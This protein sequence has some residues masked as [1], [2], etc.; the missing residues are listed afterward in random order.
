MD[1]IDHGPRLKKR[2]CGIVSSEG[3]GRQPRGVERDNVTLGCIL[4]LTQTG[5]RSSR[6]WWNRKDSIM[7][8]YT[9][10]RNSHRS[11]TKKVYILWRKKTKGDLGLDF[12]RNFWVR[13]M[14]HKCICSQEELGGH[15]GSSLR[16]F[17]LWASLSLF[18]GCFEA[19]SLYKTLSGKDSALP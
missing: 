3:N 10:W 13:D 15:Q 17:S 8:S 1:R 16:P 7:P 14:E 11:V 4:N 12:R 2:C 9:F 19:R 18:W 6:N 5:L